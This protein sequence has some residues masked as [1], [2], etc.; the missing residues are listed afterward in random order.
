[1]TNVKK[2]IK[3]VDAMLNNSKVFNGNI[4][5]SKIN[6]KIDTDT[7]SQLNMGYAEDGKM[8]SGYSSA[9]EKLS[10]LY[11][12]ATAEANALRMAQD[13]LSESTV[14][15]I[16]AKQNW[17]KAEREAAINSQAFKTAQM[18]STAIINA[19][20]TATWAN[21]AATKALSV[22]KKAVSVIAGSLLTAAISV[23]ISSLVKLA[24]N[25]ITTKKEIKEAAETSRQAIDD[26]K[27]A[28]EEL[29][30]ATNDIK[31]RYAELAQGVDQINGKNVKLSDDEYEEFLSLS[32]KLAEL[33]PSL[34]KNYDKN[35]NAIVGLTG[36][37]DSIV[38]SLD[39]LIQKE[40][41]L[42]NQDILDEMPN[43]Y[44]E[45]ANNVSEYNEQLNKYKLFKDAIP[46]DIEVDLRGRTSFELNDSYY[47]DKDT[48][49]YIKDKFKEKFEEYELDTAI[50]NTN[51][52]SDGVLQ[53][54]ITGLRNTEEYREKI[55]QIYSEIK[56]DLLKHIQEINGSIESEM[57][58]FN[59]YIYTW[60]SFDEDYANIDND[61]LKTAIQ[62]LLFNSNWIND[63]PSNINTTEWSKELEEWLKTNY[64]DAINN[65]NAEDYKQKLVDLFTMDLDPTEQI[66]IAQ[67]L[68]AYF[69]E[70]SIAV[71]LD[72][73]L[74]GDNPDSAQNLVNRMDTSIS[75]IAGDDVRSSNELKKYTSG[76]SEEQMNIWLTVTDGITNAGEAIRKYEENVSNLP[77]PE[78]DFF[79]EDNKEQVD[80][81]KDKISDLGTYLQSIN[82]KH[83]LSA[84]EISTL[85][86]E[87]GI[88]A[89]SV[90]EYKQKIIEL[91]NEAVRNS[92][93][94]TI[95]SEAIE[96]CTDEEEKQRLQSLY[97]TLSQL[98]T[99][100]QDGADSFGRLETA[101]SSLQGKA[102]LLRDVN[103]GIKDVGYI[104]S[105][106]LDDIV[107][108]YPELSTKVAEY[109]A[110]LITSS[111]LFGELETAYKQDEKKY[112]L[113]VAEKLKYNESFYDDVIENI[114]DWLK[115]QAE[116]YGID[117]DEYKNLCETKLALDKEYARKKAM[118]ESAKN[119]S[120]YL[121]E[122][123]E[124]THTKDTNKGTQLR[125]Q[126]DSLSAYDDY[127]DANKELEEYEA[128][129]EEFDTTLATTITARTSWREYGKD[130]SDLT[131]IDWTEQ[132]LSV[133][134]NKVD[135]LQNALDNTYGIENQI[136]AIDDLNDALERLK[137]GYESAYENYEGRYE[138]ALGK[139]GNSSSIQAKIESGEEFSLEKYDPETAK[140]IQEAI[141]SY[142]KML[143][144][145]QKIKDIT[146]QINKNENEEK[147]KLRLDSYQ[148]QADLI[149]SMLED[150][151]LT[152]KEKNK[153]LERE[154]EIKN[155]ILQ[156]NLLLAKTEEERLKMQEDYNNYLQQND[157][158]QYENT[159]DDINSRISYYDSRVQDVQN[160][161]ALKEAKGG[162]ASQEDYEKM[163]GF[164]DQQI[165][166]EKKNLKNAK[167][168]RDQATW[169][170]PEYEYYN[171]QIQQAQDNINACKLAQIENNKAILLLPVKKYEDANKALQEEL[172]LLNEQQEK[173]ESAIGYA[174]TLV[175][176]QIDMLNDQKENVTDY[177]DEQIKAVEKERDALTESNDE[178]QRQIDL[179][180]AKFALE[181]AMNNKTTRV[182]RKN[183]GF[184]Y[185]ADQEEIRSAQSE[186]DNLIYENAVNDF[187]K[188]IKE[189]N[190]KKTNELEDIDDDIKLWQK[191]A[192][193]IQDVTGSYEK[194]KAKQDFIEVYGEDAE[195][196]ILNKDQSI[197]QDFSVTLNDVKAEVDTVQ[198]KIEFNE[199]LIKSI[200]KIAEEY[201]TTYL[202][203]AD[204]QKQ[205][206]AILTANEDEIGAVEARSD[207]TSD[208]GSTWTDT[209]EDVDSSLD[210]IEQSNVEAK[211]NESTILDDRLEALK[212]FKD[213][214]VGY[215]NEIADAVTSAQSAFETLQDVLTKTKSTYQEM[216]DYNNK[217]NSIKSSN[218]G[219]SNNGKSNNNK[220]NN[221]KKSTNSGLKNNKVYAFQSETVDIYH[222]GGIVGNGNDLPRNLIALTNDN[223]KPNEVMA[224]LLNNEVVLNQ[225]QMGNLFNNLGATYKALIPRQSGSND[226][227]ITIGDIQVYNPDNSDMIVNEIV[228]ELPL[229]VIQ[230]LNSKK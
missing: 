123:N 104:D 85:N 10:G 62:E 91:M 1:M 223:L 16:L 150:E 132:S 114:P 197:I 48:I 201:G 219:N 183:E 51:Y 128:F 102:E 125:D 127:M 22:A 194:S 5:N 199:K 208:Y 224:K 66:K 171:D 213:T 38:S 82:E 218:N 182:Y 149:S 7:L 69:D 217:I 137:G 220:S 25:V 58:G 134:Q 192:E 153:L 63:L 160:S 185:E 130:K 225:H 61:G 33:F 95:L 59:E 100:A 117:F 49:K 43:V 64:L 193:A 161:I 90:E 141:D 55:N 83:E 172:D 15:D 151:S 77:N 11:K 97:N 20:T 175:Q 144:T 92:E 135:E 188:Q 198:S 105:S 34:T 65:I 196:K 24:D 71:S 41:E 39:D 101:I 155:S 120:D 158:T 27:S 107:S 154:K 157:K 205:I 126:V 2:E 116:A 118:L 228:K 162:Q 163:N 159:R 99:E 86:V 56:V 122:L 112:K 45:L 67:E 229:K 156:Q 6:N 147:V 187:D 142:N 210:T 12:E 230:K 190:E 54:N 93:V 9:I 115:E 18:G 57:D 94:M 203:V 152:A 211:D 136:A 207:A 31:E 215:Y 173:L 35:G 131:E 138:K 212:I 222:D 170:T 181:K 186:L 168:M 26:I 50:A 40:R 106:K 75:A 32:N 89:G 139:L 174:S 42:A 37:V 166:W 146:D 17:S 133:L 79:T 124:N 176:D 178:L 4:V 8:T 81:Y 177:W 30:G 179:E 164:L 44:K 96:A 3:D 53:F 189:M 47:F 111:E 36:D 13:G 14:K 169:G 121:I 78:I 88:V 87:Y 72:F 52:D 191:Y 184:V 80:A 227:S 145:K 119:K 195:A 167:A 103:Q 23:G 29:E 28:F 214:A 108:A 21:V 110:E 221:N 165:A 180:N 140:Y 109:N 84:D 46:S 60:L 209:K 98:P 76:F 202:T 73:I 200:Q 143:E 74:D 129:L 68:Q 204:A 206:E 19:D 70:N 113:S 216:V 226:I 148:S